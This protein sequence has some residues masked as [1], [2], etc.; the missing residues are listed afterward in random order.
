M[1]AP[2]DICQVLAPLNWHAADDERV[3]YTWRI[4]KNKNEPTAIT[5]H[6]VHVYSTNKDKKAPYDHEGWTTGF[7]EFPCDPA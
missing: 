3:H 1:A 6:T 4:G 5:L 7:K 2:E